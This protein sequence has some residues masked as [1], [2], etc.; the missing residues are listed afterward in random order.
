MFIRA[1]Q[2]PTYILPEKFEVELFVLGLYSTHII[3]GVFQNVIMWIDLK[4]VDTCV[5][6]FSKSHLVKRN[7]VAK[8]F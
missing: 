6:T 8:Y 7:D 3:D 2:K 5:E 4:Q 1:N